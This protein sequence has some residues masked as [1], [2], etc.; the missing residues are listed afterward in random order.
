M[1]ILL[2]SLTLFLPAAAH[3]ADSKLLID[4]MECESGGRYNVVGDDGVSVGIA[5]FQKATFETLKHKAKMPWLQWKNPI[6]QMRL[7]NWAIDHG[8]GRLWTCYRKL[9]GVKK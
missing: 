6:H 9:K 2:L 8:Y 3:A 1:R 4:I 7:L 5:Q